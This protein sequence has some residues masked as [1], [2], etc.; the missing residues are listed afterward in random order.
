MI[1]RTKW[2]TRIRQSKRDRQQN[3]QK[4]NDKQQSTKHYAE[5]ERSI[6]TKL[7]KNRG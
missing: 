2:I 7:I 4:K 5:N 1:L 3:G 6:K